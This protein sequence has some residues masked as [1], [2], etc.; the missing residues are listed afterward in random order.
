MQIL[1]HDPTN[2]DIRCLSDMAQKIWTHPYGTSRSATKK[3]NLSIKFSRFNGPYGPAKLTHECPLNLELLRRT[4]HLELKSQRYEGM[5]QKALLYQR[6]FLGLAAVFMIL[7]FYAFT[8]NLVIVT[9]FFGNLHHLPTNGISVISLLLAGAALKT[10]LSV[11]AIKESTA[12]LSKR[13]IAR[14]ASLCDVEEEDE[15]QFYGFACANRQ[16]Q[17]QIYY[18]AMQA[19][20]EKQE[21]IK[22]ILKR[23]KKSPILTSDEKKYLFKQ[24]L[25][26]M[27]TELQE[28]MSWCSSERSFDTELPLSFWKNT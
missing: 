24:T 26:R 15:H 4:V 18:S 22:G 13:A 9:S 20:E 1:K 25:Y 10:G 11:C 17:K 5:L 28:L 7:A 19:I 27:D 16:K 23:I 21:E 3:S 6:T 14:I 8:H 2:K 12:S